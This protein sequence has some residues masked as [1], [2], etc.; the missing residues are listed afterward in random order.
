LEAFCQGKERKKRGNKV[1]PLANR[2]DTAGKSYTEKINS[3]TILI[4]SLE[5]TLKLFTF[6]TK[7]EQN[8]KVRSAM[9]IMIQ[10]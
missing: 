9:Q 4:L 1:W 7:V 3:G 8:I 10:N 6:A 5:A 2:R